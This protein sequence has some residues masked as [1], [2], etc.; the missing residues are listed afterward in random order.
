MVRVYQVCQQGFQPRR[1]V[2]NEAGK[3]S[4]GMHR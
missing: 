2:T 1:L 4:A 3:S